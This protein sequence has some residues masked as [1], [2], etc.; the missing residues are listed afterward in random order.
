MQFKNVLLVSPTEIIANSPIQDN[1]DEK[2]LAKTLS[3]VQ[4]TGL[5]QIVGTTLYSG[6]TDA[7]YYNV[8]SATT[9]PQLYQDLL[10]VSKPY[11]IAKTTSDFL[12][13]NNYKITNKGVLKL[14]DNT[15]NNLSEGDLQAVKDYF[16]NLISTYKQDVIDFLS[17]N[18]LISTDN[19]IQTT[20]YAAGW[21]LGIPVDVC[22]VPNDLPVVNVDDYL[23][24]NVGSFT[25]TQIGE[26][27]NI[28]LISGQEII[29]N[30]VIQDNVDVKLLAKTISLVQDVYLKD[31]LT[32]TLYFGLLD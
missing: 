27:K 4:Q 8:V 1:I 14:N 2:L 9:I 30:S 32:P 17:D 25:Y 3:T 20:S 22:E 23:T 15:A 28:L 13:F 29:A 24:I 19:D 16:D 5:R 6:L 18:N 12:I 26:L 7:V 11:L 21:Y 10:A 31:I